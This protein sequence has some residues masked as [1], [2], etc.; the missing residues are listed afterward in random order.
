VWEVGGIIPEISLYNNRTA[1][2][3]LEYNN[4]ISFNIFLKR[5]FLSEK[6]VLVNGNNFAPNLPL[7]VLRPLSLK[8]QNF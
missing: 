6:P 3:F 8:Y 5:Y 2:H 4:N 7:I 1:T